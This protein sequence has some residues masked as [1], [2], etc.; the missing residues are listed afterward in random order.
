M[1]GLRTGDLITISYQGQELP[2]EVM[3]ASSN[4]RS[5]VVGF[6]GILAGFA[7]MMAIL[8]EE[9]GTAKVILRDTEVE[10]RRRQ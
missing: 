1:I 9:D 2:G 4:S 8:V 3:L 5:L 10:L 7:G 6:E